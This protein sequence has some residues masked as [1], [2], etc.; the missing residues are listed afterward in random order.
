MRTIKTIFTSLV[1]FIFISS[2]T[3]AQ[4]LPMPSPLGSV[5]QKV[6]L[7]DITIEYSRPGVKGRTIFGDLVAY[8]KL[9][10]TGANMATKISFSSDVVINGNEL[11]AGE[12]AI[13]TI[14]GKEEWTFILNSNTNQGGTG[15]YSKDLDVLRIQVKPNEA[16]MRETMT[17]TIDDVKNGSA[18]IT[19]HWE[20]TSISVP[21]EVEYMDLAKE[22]ID[23]KLKELDGAYSSYNQIARFYVENNINLPEA[24]KLAQK[25]VDMNQKFWNVYTLSLALAANKKYKEAIDIAKVSKELAMEAEY[26]VYVKR[27]DANIAKWNKM[28]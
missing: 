13:F 16:P 20:K 23:N 18:T 27:N 7:T 24:L 8:D 11:K 25:S 10:R 9:W 6:G 2:N 26:D 5:S 28:K 3:T 14:P 12:Y 21:L 15:S 4:N 1:L 19:L 17:F 22:N